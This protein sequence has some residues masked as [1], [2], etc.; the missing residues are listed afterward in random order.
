VRELHNNDSDESSEES[1]VASAG[2]DETDTET[3]RLE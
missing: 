2:K 1:N 3:E